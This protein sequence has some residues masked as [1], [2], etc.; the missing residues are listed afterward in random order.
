VERVQTGTNLLVHQIL[1][2]KKSG[3]VEQMAIEAL[4]LIV[5]SKS[6]EAE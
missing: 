4:Q 3:V 5:L 2:G 1:V 6:S